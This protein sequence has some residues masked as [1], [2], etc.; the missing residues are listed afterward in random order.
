MKYVGEIMSYSVKEMMNDIPVTEEEEE[1]WGRRV[2]IDMEYRLKDYYPSPG[3]GGRIIKITS[4]FYGV[5]VPPPAPLDNE[6]PLHPTPPPTWDARVKRVEWC[7]A[8]LT[9]GEQHLLYRML[10]HDGVR[11]DACR[12]EERRERGSLG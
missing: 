10:Y 3:D 2:A 8:N 12:D 11:Y 4:D 6:G 9:K 1:E 5:G 7:L